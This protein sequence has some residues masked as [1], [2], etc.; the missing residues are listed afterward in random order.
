M[1]IMRLLVFRL[2]GH[3]AY[4]GRDSQSVRNNIQ[5]IID[6]VGLPLAVV[7]SVMMITRFC[8]VAM[9][10]LNGLCVK[11]LWQLQRKV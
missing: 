3:D 6:H 5:L 4:P 1:R 7:R 2:R 8:V 9:V 11:Y 10:S